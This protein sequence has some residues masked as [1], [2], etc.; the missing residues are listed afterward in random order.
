MFEAQECERINFFRNALW[1]H[2]N[3][4]SQQCVTDDEVSEKQ[5]QKTVLCVWEPPEQQEPWMPVSSPS[6]HFLLP[7]GVQSDK[8]V[9]IAVVFLTP[10]PFYHRDSLRNCELADKET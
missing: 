5:S 2:L 7:F 10:G 4:L 9:S 8:D 6:P 3:Q 1:L